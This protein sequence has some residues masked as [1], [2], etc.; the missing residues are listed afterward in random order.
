MAIN[1]E[2]L[3]NLL[4][5][6]APL[7]LSAL[8]KPYNAPGEF[9]DGDSPLSEDYINIH[10]LNAVADRGYDMGIVQDNM[11]EDFKS[12]HFVDNWDMTDSAE[13]A[14]NN[15][16]KSIHNANNPQKIS[17]PGDISIRDADF[18]NDVKNNA[19]DYNVLKSISP[20]AASASVF[21]QPRGVKA[22]AQNLLGKVKNKPF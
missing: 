13:Y 19:V 11:L 7:L 16:M 2:M 1:K 8:Q 3:V 18:I 21:Q 17:F 5:N 6:S 4:M 15:T 12:P 10:N 14:L 20:A 22:L 9:Y